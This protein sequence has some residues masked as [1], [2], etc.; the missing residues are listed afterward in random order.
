MSA[1]AMELARLSAYVDG[2]LGPADELDLRRHLDT[3]AACAR[4]IETLLALK[5]AVAMSG[6]VRPVPHTLRERLAA[7]E[8]PRRRAWRP[9]L[10]HVAALTAV[11]LAAVVAAHW[12]LRPAG[13]GDRVA[14][15][16]VADHLHFLQVPDALEVVSD[17]PAQIA[18][19]FA[20][21]VSFPVRVPR[22]SG[23]TLLGG[24]FC[25]LWGHE[26]AL[27][28]YEVKG[29]RLSLFVTDPETLAGTPRPTG[30]SSTLGG[31]RVCLVPAAPTVLAMVGD[32]EQTAALFPALRQAAAL[33]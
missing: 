19:W 28:F 26:V 32:A 11:V 21:K 29:R 33:E 13:S 6:D 12:V 1:C 8:Q 20:D 5:E 17:D 24:R 18:A 7:L 2:E 30:C 4:T 3:C 16:L 23:A 25:S 14:E 27:T 15:A 9:R 10:L 31:Y 22:L